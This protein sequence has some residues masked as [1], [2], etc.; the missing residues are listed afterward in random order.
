MFGFIEGPIFKSKKISLF[1]KMKKN[2]IDREIHGYNI[3]S[4]FI[5]G[6]QIYVIF[7]GMSIFRILAASK[8]FDPW[9]VST[10]F[11]AFILWLI[12]EIIVNRLYIKK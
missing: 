2:F 10:F 8:K 11:F 1:I 12:G 6:L 5:I 4:G 7:E 9:Q 3:L